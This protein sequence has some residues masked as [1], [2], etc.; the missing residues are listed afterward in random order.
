[1][2]APEALERVQ[3]CRDLPSAGVMIPAGAPVMSVFASAETVELA[4]AQLER[5]AHEVG[6]Q[7]ARWEIDE[8][9]KCPI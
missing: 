3:W 4:Q 9:S 7:L 5:R 2:R 1:V 8:P 6:Q